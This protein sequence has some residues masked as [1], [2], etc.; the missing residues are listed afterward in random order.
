MSERNARPRPPGRRTATCRE[1]RWLSVRARSLL[2]LGVATVLVGLAAS[3]AAAAALSLSEAWRLAEERSLA[4]PARDASAAAARHLAVAAGRRPDPVLVGLATLPVSGDNRFST[5]RGPGFSATRDPMTRLSVGLRQQFTRGSKLE[6][7][8]AVFEREANVALADRELARSQL[9]RGTALAWFDLHYRQRIRDTLIAQRDEA[10]LQIDAAEAAYRGGRGAQAD[11]FGAR[12]GVAALEDRMAA[13]ERQV[14]SAR[15]QLARWV[16]AM[17]A[18]PLAAAPPID[19]LPL[20]EASLERQLELDPRVEL[21][22]RREAVALANADVARSERHSDISAELAY[23]QRGP[24]Y[25]NLVSLVLSMPL[26]WDQKNKQDQELAARLAV[27]DQL[28][29]EREEALRSYVLEALT[30]LQ[31]WRDNGGRIARYDNTLVPLSADRTRAALAA[32]RGGSGS[33]ATLLQAREAEVAT[34][35]EQLRLQADTARLWAQLA[36]LLP[37]ARIDMKPRQ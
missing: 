27:V 2:G 24:A 21:L 35:L 9:R 16:G 30:L 34:R 22:R 25:S 31:E 23:T 32:Y 4:L 13:A 6:A 29:S 5:T 18:E 26:Q 7:R 1:H 37:D 8:S 14:V 11:V 20:D 28:R 17:A 33:L 15:S 10:G 3:D 19:V 12:S 36:T